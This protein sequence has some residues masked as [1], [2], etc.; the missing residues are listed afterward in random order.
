MVYAH[1][2][3]NSG[4]GKSGSS[5]LLRFVQKNKTKE[6]LLRLVLRRRRCVKMR[7][8]LLLRPNKPPRTNY[9]LLPPGY[10]SC[11]ASLLPHLLSHLRQRPLR[12]SSSS[13]ALVVVSAQHSPSTVQTLRLCFDI[14][15]HSLHRHSRCSAHLSHLRLLASL[16]EG[17]GIGS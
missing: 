15:G 8:Q 16:E 12:A 7:R 9:H 4:T 2:R 3:P 17:R 1:P 6:A 5:S 14:R 11:A 13:V 10:P